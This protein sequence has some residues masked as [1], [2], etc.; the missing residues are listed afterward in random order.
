MKDLRDFINVLREAGEINPVSQ[1]VDWYL[2]AGAIASRANETGAPAPLFTQIKDYP[3][4]Y[5]L[6]GSPL[7]SSRLNKNRPWRRFSLAMGLE[8]DSDF[9]HLAEEYIRRRKHPLKPNLLDWGPCKENILQGKEVDIL[10]F[11]IPFIHQGDGGR[12]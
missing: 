12:Y 4:G 11:P 9:W 2:E 10:K 8:A 5:G 6:L 7:A 3:T 1:P